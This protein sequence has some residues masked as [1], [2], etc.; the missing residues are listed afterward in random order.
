M[1]QTTIMKQMMNFNK[2]AFDNAYNAMAMLQEQ[3]EKMA[4][5]SMKQATWIPEEGKKFADEWAKA[6]RQGC[7]DFRNAV[8]ANFKKAEDFFTGPEKAKKAETKK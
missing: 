1:E 8:D 7:E 6:Y 3:T 5:M 2:A 4:K